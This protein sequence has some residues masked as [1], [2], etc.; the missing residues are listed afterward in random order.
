MRSLADR[1]KFSHATLAGSACGCTWRPRLTITCRWPQSGEMKVADHHFCA[2][3]GASDDA[4]CKSFLNKSSYSADGIPIDGLLLTGHGLIPRLSRP[5]A[6]PLSQE[7]RPVRTVPQ[8]RVSAHTVVVGAYCSITDLVKPFCYQSTSRCPQTEQH[9]AA[10]SVACNCTAPTKQMTALDRDTH[11]TSMTT[12]VHSIR[13]AALI[14]IQSHPSHDPNLHFISSCPVS[15][16]PS[17]AS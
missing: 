11:L 7:S 4:R 10:S 1:R 5:T 15:L 12:A 17:T 3:R 6:T 13:Y 8:C 14:V 16:S 2:A 9:V